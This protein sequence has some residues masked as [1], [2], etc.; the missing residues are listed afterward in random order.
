M[1]LLT[2]IRT[3]FTT[4]LTLWVACFVLGISGLVFFLMERFSQNGI[5]EELVETTLQT[6]ENT[7]L[8]VDNILRQ[9]EMRARLENQT[10]RVNRRIIEQQIEETGYHVVLKQSLPHAQLYVTR[11]DS[12]QIGSFFASGERG[13]RL[14][15]H[16]GKNSYFF[17]E[18]LGERPFSIV[19]ISPA[20]DIH[21]KYRD[22]HYAFLS[23]GIVGIVCLLFILYVIIGRHLRPLHQLA[24]SAQTIADGHLDAT[25][26][27]SRHQD[28][29]G[30]LQNSLKKMQESLAAYMDEMNQ[31]Q[32]VLTQQNAELQ[33]AYGEAQAYEELKTKHLHEMTDKMEEP[34]AQLCR[35]TDTM[36]RD[37]RRLT[38]TEVNQLQTGIMEATETITRLLDATFKNPAAL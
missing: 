14:I 15:E 12:S 8:R 13:Y 34:V 4:Q 5:R 18:A 10:F 1:G 27:N 9:S 32:M 3:S 26:A 2:K 22:M 23:G 7:A 24:D 19:V 25:I 38:K 16:D 20:E 33:A 31:K 11:R 30:R 17:Y 29:T 6:L 36:C 28:E 35:N 37:Y 21:E